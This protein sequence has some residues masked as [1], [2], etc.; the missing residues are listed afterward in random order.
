MASAGSAAGEASSCRCVSSRASSAGCSWRSSGQRIE[1][2]KLRFF[3]DL[4]GFGRCASVRCIH[5]AVAR[6]EWVVFA[7]RP[8]AGPGQVLSYLSRYTHRVAIS[9]RR[10]VA[11]DAAD[12]AFTWK[13]Y[14]H[15][16][17]PKTMVLTADEFIRRFLLHVLPD[18]FQ[19]IRHYGFLANGAREESLAQARELLQAVAGTATD[20]EDEA[21]ADDATGPAPRD[22][23]PLLR[24][25]DRHR[26]VRGRLSAP[27]HADHQDRHLMTIPAAAAAA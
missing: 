1:R 11:L 17:S 27:P 8:F 18:G 16:S 12:V 26:D 13:D 10:L 2:G 4:A 20:P 3:G 22:P 23:M 24:P 21:A 15:G 5:R 6:T 25:H 19:R 7:K 14:R 9:N